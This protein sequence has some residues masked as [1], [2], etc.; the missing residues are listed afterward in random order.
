[1]CRETRNMKVQLS[2]RGAN[3][4]PRGGRVLK[5]T[6]RGAGLSVY[7]GLR[8]ERGN[9]TCVLPACAAIPC[10]L[11]F[12]VL[13]LLPDANVEIIFDIT[14]NVSIIFTEKIAVPLSERFP[15]SSAVLSVQSPNRLIFTI[16]TLFR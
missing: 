13:F 7:N 2:E 15:N 16:R 12:S 6:S 4:K 8:Y 14:A 3:G 1:M 9:R 10:F 11:L 5:G